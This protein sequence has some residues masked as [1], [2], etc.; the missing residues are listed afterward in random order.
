M[1]VV[2]DF[3]V[4][5][6]IDVNRTE[7]NRATIALHIFEGAGEMSHKSVSNNRA[8]VHNQQLLN[9]RSQIGNDSAK[10]LRCLE[11]TPETLTASFRE[12]AVNETLRERRFCV[13]FIARI[14]EGRISPGGKDYL[15]RRRHLEM[16]Q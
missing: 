3:P 16:E 8:I 9:L 7:A 14:P 11:N 5:H 15:R 4:L 10:V 1:P 13:A 6:A 2:G 12:G